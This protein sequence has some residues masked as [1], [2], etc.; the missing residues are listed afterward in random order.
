MTTK[1]PDEGKPEITDDMLKEFAGNPDKLSSLDPE[2]LDN[3]LVELDKREQGDGGKVE[4]PVVKPD[5]DK[6]DDNA[7]AAVDDKSTDSPDD[8]RDNEIAKLRESLRNEHKRE[9]DEL[10]KITQKTNSI[11]KRIEKRKAEFEELSKKEVDLSKVDVDPVDE[12]SFQEFVKRMETDK[13][14]K[15]R[16]IEF[17][18]QQLLE[19][20]Q[21][22]LSYYESQSAVSKE[23]SAFENI[24]SLQK[25][26]PVLQT[27]EPIEALNSG[28]AAFLDGLVSVA[29][30]KDRED[31]KDKDTSVLRDVALKLYDTDPVFKQKATGLGVSLPPGLQDQKE[32]EKYEIITSLY[33]KVQD[34]GGSIK[35]HWLEHLDKTG[36]L[37]SLYNKGKRDAALDA[38]RATAD[39]IDNNSP[40][41]L[42]PS[43]GPG[44]KPSGAEKMTM[45]KAKMRAQALTE[46]GIDRRLTAEEVGE[47]DKLLEF[48]DV[49]EG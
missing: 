47:L 8:K 4:D 40:T 11:K 25:D 32:M 20:D 31:F 17:L 35:G 15:D 29:G 34:D 43:D 24:E 23:K 27:K 7:D 16:E 42:D 37:E 41:P 28:Y 21:D 9:A 5:P 22:N 10:N 1:N 19:Q 39:A 36:Q 48:L 46:A 26:Y 18:K 2:T 13:I 14:R 49:V 33:Q 38:A 44:E 6:S 12:K 30:L 45:E 3:V